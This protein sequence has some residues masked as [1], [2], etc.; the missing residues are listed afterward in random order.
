MSDRHAFSCL[1]R[2]S[3]QHQII[4]G[5]ESLNLEIVLRVDGVLHILLRDI[6]D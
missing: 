4:I 3:I 5:D 2:F 6:K 1:G